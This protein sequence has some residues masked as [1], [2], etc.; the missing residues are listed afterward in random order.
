MGGPAAGDPIEPAADAIAAGASAAAAAQRGAAY[1]PTD[2]PP[3]TPPPNLGTTLRPGSPNPYAVSGV[4]EFE[5]RC[6]FSHRAAHDPIVAPGNPAISHVHDFFGNRTTDHLSTLG[7]LTAQASSC[8]PAI[9]SSAYW[10]PTLVAGGVPVDPVSAQ[11]YYQVRRPQDPAKVRAMP[12]GLRMIAG[13]AMA[14]GPQPDYVI[15]WQCLATRRP[16]AT[17]PDCGNDRMQL[18]IEFPDCWN[19]LSLDS[20][21][22][23]SHMAYARGKD[24]PA[25]HPV[26]VPQ[27]SFRLVYPVSGPGVAVSSDLMA[28]HEMPGGTTAHG[29][30]I[31][32]WPDAEFERR[33]ATCITTPRVCDVDGNVVH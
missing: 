13:E 23:R 15:Q 22:H 14:S 16:S 28:G 33:L 8:R 4:G 18:L 29:D 21:D 6:A 7:S 10:V 9:D 2:A 32:V 20:P 17:I 5:A 26:L 27:L 30:F 3:P 19:G 1:R 31:Q 12:R 24:C 11:V 25:T